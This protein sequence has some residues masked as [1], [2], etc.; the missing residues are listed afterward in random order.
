VAGVLDT[1]FDS[2]AFHQ[3]PL[4][5]TRNCIEY[6]S[7]SDLFGEKRKRNCIENSVIFNNLKVII[8][9]VKKKIKKLDR[10]VLFVI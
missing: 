7:S 10:Q 1:T 6:V 9:F 3:K 2:I 5:L 4:E 8:I